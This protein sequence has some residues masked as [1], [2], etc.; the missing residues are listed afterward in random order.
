MINFI[1]YENEKKMQIL[2][3]DIIQKFMNVKEFKYKIYEFN[4]F[5]KE[6]YKRI[7]NNL[8]GKKIYLLGLDGPGMSS[9]DFARSIRNDG[10]W[11]SQIIIIKNY[12]KYKDTNFISRLLMVDFVSKFDD[13]RKELNFSLEIAFSVLNRQ[14]ALA[15]KCNNEIFQIL[16]NDIYYI[17][18][19]LND[20]DST[21]VT[22]NNKCIIKC[23]INKLNEILS[24][25][26]RF[27]K[28]HRSCIVNINNII[29]FDMS[30]NIIKFKDKETNL[31]SRNKKKELKERIMANNNIS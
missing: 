12:K 5:K 4:C 8:T 21:I 24:N 1:I 10:D 16:Y 23:S 30:N 26:P 18:K 14:L 11:C 19:N 17:E 29:S 13:I 22:R 9:L 20:N 3:K 15:F 28:C 6:C 25:D 2:Y 31:V 27:F 7:N